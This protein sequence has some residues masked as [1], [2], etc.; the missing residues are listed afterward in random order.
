MGQLLRTP[1]STLRDRTRTPHNRPKGRT[2]KRTKIGGLELLGRI[3]GA[4]RDFRILTV[5]IP[6]TDKYLSG[7]VWMSDISGLNPASYIFFS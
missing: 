4:D 1:K 2:Q 6:G 3:H 7:K 5:R